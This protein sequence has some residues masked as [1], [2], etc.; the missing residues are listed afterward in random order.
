MILFFE[1][2]DLIELIACRHTTSFVEHHRG[3]GEEL[4]VQTTTYERSRLE[5]GQIEELS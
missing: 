3:S 2:Q 4:H 5:M 1:H